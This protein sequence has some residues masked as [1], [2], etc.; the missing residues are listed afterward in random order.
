MGTIYLVYL[1]VGVRSQDPTY[2]K[3]QKDQSKNVSPLLVLSFLLH[4]M[5]LLE[6]YSLGSGPNFMKD[7]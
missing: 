3:L 4:R 1:E 2:I 5:I 7:S 6:K